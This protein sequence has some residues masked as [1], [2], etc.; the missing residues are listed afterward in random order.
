M[1]VS[2]N[3]ENSTGLSAQ[4][5]NNAQPIFDSLIELESLRNFLVKGEKSKDNIRKLHYY[6][7][8][9]SY[10]PRDDFILSFFRKLNEKLTDP[11][12]KQFMEGMI[13]GMNKLAF[14]I[15]MIKLN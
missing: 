6:Y 11:E 1:N 13:N 9:F 8:E 10:I 3:P 7:K 2:L 14:R 4:L 15:I 12:E 5:L